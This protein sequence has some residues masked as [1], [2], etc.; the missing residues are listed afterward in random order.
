MLGALVGA[1][2]Y[3]AQIYAECDSND[4]VSRN[5]LA[6]DHSRRDAAAVGEIV[7]RKV[8]SRTFK[9]RLASMQY[10]RIIMFEGCVWM[11][12]LGLSV[13]SKTIAARGRPARHCQR[14]FLP[15]SWS[16]LGQ[17]RALTLVA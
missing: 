12:L 13:L 17:R 3:K 6:A 10:E 5:L 2:L 16:G 11:C 15:L 7:G 1:V 14:A 4:S 8:K 9:R